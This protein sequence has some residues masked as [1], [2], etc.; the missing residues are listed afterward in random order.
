[1]LI[2]GSLVLL[3]CL[4]SVA[5]TAAMVQF[6]PRWGLVDAPDGHRKLQSHA[7]PLGGGLALAATC[8]VCLIV[9]VLVP[10]VVAEKLA[11]HWRFVFGLTGAAAL[12]VTVGLLDDLYDIRARHKLLAQV[13]ATSVIVAAG[14]TIQRISLFGWVVELG[15]LAIVFTVAWLIGAINAFNL[16]DGLDGLA[17]TVGVI[18]AGTVGVL[19]AATG[20]VVEAAICSVLVGAMLG[21]LVFN[22]FPARIY[23]GDA[24]SMLLGLVLGV[25]AMRV[26]LKE[27]ATLAVAVPIVVWAVLFF[28]VVIAILRRHLTGQS[29]YTTDRAHI[30]H[31]LRRHGYSVPGVVG[32][33]GVAC[34]ACCCGGLAGVWLGSE[35]LTLG[36]TGLVLGTMVL[37]GLFGRSE[38]GLWWRWAER[39]FA[40]W[41]QFSHRRP[42]APEPVIS[43]FHGDRQWEHLWTE[44]LEYAERF[45]LSAVQLNVSAPAIGEEYHALWSRKERANLRTQWRSEIPLFVGELAVGRLTVSGR[46]AHG[47]TTIDSMSELVHGLKPF[48]VQME[49][50]LKHTVQQESMDPVEALEFHSQPLEGRGGKAVIRRVDQAIPVAVYEAAEAVFQAGENPGGAAVGTTVS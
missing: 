30:H 18:A 38:L 36:A 45:D 37:S 29:I 22:W 35:V 10:S 9:A 23:L 4:I 1:M 19:A 40:S 43:R 2:Y 28:D 49:A 8:A 42:G 26:S 31:V 13:V 21:F 33:I 17:G 14:L 16:I 34:L 32:V 50:I 44:L 41:L 6:A 5:L 12:M 47:A 48:Q 46:M 39:F 20:H 15:P 27:T 24:G 7:I 3:A 11:A 25:L